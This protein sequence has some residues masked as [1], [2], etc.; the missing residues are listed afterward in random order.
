MVPI[1]FGLDMMTGVP[2]VASV[3]NTRQANAASAGSRSGANLR[4]VEGHLR[5]G[6]FLCLQ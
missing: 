2:G 5:K 3:G 1:S 4:L 6:V